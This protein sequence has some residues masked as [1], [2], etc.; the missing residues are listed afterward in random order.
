MRYQYKIPL[1]EEK[2]AKYIYL[3]MAKKNGDTR[4]NEQLMEEYHS[5]RMPDLPTEEMAALQKWATKYN[6]TIG[7]GKDWVSQLRRQ[8]KLHPEIPFDE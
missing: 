1:L 7:K 4:S 3:M 6:M 8:I 5:N 2:K